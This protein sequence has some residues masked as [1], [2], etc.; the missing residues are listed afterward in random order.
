MSFICSLSKGQQS[1][2]YTV[3]LPANTTI[4]QLKA[5]GLQVQNKY[6]LESTTKNFF[7]DF[8]SVRTSDESLLKSLV[9]SGDLLYWEKQRA[10]YFHFTPSYQQQQ[11][12]N[13]N[14]NS[15]RDDRSKGGGGVSDR[16]GG[17]VRRD[18][19]KRR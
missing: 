4:S 13:T 3:K 15:R 9:N 19:I 17:R 2:I 10:Q 7:S 8:L 1:H 5:S 16:D 12:G 11:R 18:N 14:N 6:N